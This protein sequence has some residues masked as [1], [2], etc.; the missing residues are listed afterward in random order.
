MIAKKFPQMKRK[1][2]KD[3]AF[4]AEK[5]KTQMNDTPTEELRDFLSADK[6]QWRIMAL[7]CG[8]IGNWR[9]NLGGWQL[10]AGKSEGWLELHT[11]I[12]YRY[13]SN[14][15]DAQNFLDRKIQFLDSHAVLLCLSELLVVRQTE[16][17][18][19]LAN[20]IQPCI[21]KNVFVDVWHESCFRVFARCLFLKLKRNEKACIDLVK[22]YDVGPYKGLL[23]DWDNPQRLHKALLHT[24]DYHIANSRKDDGDF[25]DP[26]LSVMPMELLAY[27]RVRQDMG[28][29][30]PEI[31]HP[32]MDLPF[33][34]LPDEFPPLDDPILAEIEEKYPVYK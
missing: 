25:S 11:G 22:K 15:L 14:E 29:E 26:V 34:K 32:L 3:M 18:Q 23:E 13:W 33:D 16:K 31:D 4:W 12:I 30:T 27:I 17:A 24:C 21:D 5:Q 19:R 6:I 28:L 7:Q 8:Q 10:F 2:I 1:A 9:R 20:L